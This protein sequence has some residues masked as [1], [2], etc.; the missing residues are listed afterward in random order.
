MYG[1]KIEHYPNGLEKIYVMNRNDGKF[2]FSR[3]SISDYVSTDEN[4]Y[5]TTHSRRPR[6]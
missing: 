2:Y 6:Q 1:Q 4:G 3:K 5:V